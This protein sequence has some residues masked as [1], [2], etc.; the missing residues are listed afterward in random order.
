MEN[1]NLFLNF[2]TTIKQEYVCLFVT[3]F[4]QFSLFGFQNTYITRA[5]YIIFP[6]VIFHKPYFF[7]MCTSSFTNH[8]AG[9]A[10]SQSECLLDV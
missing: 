1:K 5:K 8:Y 2:Q 9:K 4:L 3:Y 10:S 6:C 7:S